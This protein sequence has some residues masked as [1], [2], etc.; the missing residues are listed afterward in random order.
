MRRNERR[1]RVDIQTVDAAFAVAPAV[2]KLAG[3]SGAAI[4][5]VSCEQTWRQ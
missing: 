4:L 2:R 3:G 5:K 1:L